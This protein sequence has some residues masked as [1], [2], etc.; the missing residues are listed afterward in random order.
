[1][2]SVFNTKFALKPVV[3]ALALATAAGSAF[4]APTVNQMP[5]AGQ[6]QAV[7]LGSAGTSLTGAVIGAPITGLVN[8]AGI[9]IDGK[10]VLR[11]G[12]TG[13][14]VDAANPVGFNLG[15]NATLLF[16]AISA[17][18]A[19]LN[20]DASGNSSQIYGNLV[21]TPGPFAGCGA[22]AFAPAMFIS[23]ANGIVVGAGA[24]IVAP[25]GVGLIGANLNNTTSVNDFVA[26]NGWV[27]PA[28]PALGVSHLSY[29]TIPST[30][31]VTIAGAINGDPVLNLPAKYIIVAGNNI[32]VLNTGNLFGITV[33]LNAGV[34]A[35]PTLAAVGGL[36]NQTVNRI[37]NIDV[38][39]EEACCFVGTLPGDLNL[40]AG[41]TGNVTN[42]GSISA[43]G[44]GVGE[45]ITIQAK[46]NVRSGTQGRRRHAGGPVLGS[47][48]LH[49]LVLELEQ[50]RAVQRGV[51]LHDEQDAAVPVRQQLRV[52]VGLPSGRDD[53]GAQAGRA[54]VVDHDHGRSADLRRQRR[55]QQHDQSHGHASTSR[56]W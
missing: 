37:F 20:I 45:W 27:I 14:P 2:T 9:G 56:T 24:R 48:H 18:S 35:Q 32:D 55:D 12:G 5:G 22:C 11:W 41:A 53:R 52:A 39:L 30:G 3:A 26:N 29:G 25:T 43:A 23:N 13:A 17:N 6:L 47:G 31:N 33:E 28:A 7:S 51:G 1:M 50:G 38:G 44:T 40:V 19:V 36:S 54:A 8:G 21:S 34:V 42:A 46:G 49:R 10:V 4:A 16:G 15:S